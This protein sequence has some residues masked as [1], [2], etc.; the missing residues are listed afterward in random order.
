MRTVT[1]L[2]I[3]YSSMK[4]EDKAVK[5]SISLLLTFVLIFSVFS[6]A[7]CTDNTNSNSSEGNFNYN[8]DMQ[9]YYNNI[10]NA[11]LACTESDKGYY[12]RGDHGIVLFIDKKSMEGI[13]LCNK[14]NCMHNDPDVCDAYGYGSIQYN[15]GYLY[16]DISE[17]DSEKMSDV[18]YIFRVS[19]D[20]T[21]KEK[22]TNGFSETL[23]EWFIHRSY[24]Y[25]LTNKG[26]YR[27]PLSSPESEP[28]IIVS[29]KELGSENVNID[30]FIAYENYVYVSVSA[31]LE[32]ESSE[33]NNF[34]HLF[35]FDIESGKY[36]EIDFNGA[37]P[38]IATFIDGKMITYKS[39][40]NDDD[41]YN[42]IYY[43]S[44]LNGD[45]REKFAEYPSGNYLY[46]DGKYVYVDNGAYLNFSED[47]DYENPG[48]NIFGQTIK[49]YDL[50]MKD[51]ASFILPF[52]G[53]IDMCAQGT[54]H[55]LISNVAEDGS[56]ELY[57][58]DKNE[59]PQYKGTY[60]VKKEVCP[61]NWK[62][63][64]NTSENNNIKVDNSANK[65]N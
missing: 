5:K 63:L 65:N 42:T 13:P 17:Y 7:G 18:S 25:C 57:Y 62:N 4:K 51:I 28:K 33:D 48:K 31:L 10:S 32:E 8:T 59:I 54:G 3:I 19:E 21:E 35:A 34:T 9:Y 2:S 55:F 49:V 44:D 56:S 47:I 41:S 60:A 38:N 15:D 27:I 39:V 24:V 40:K 46:S 58:I 11:K 61:L 12:Y 22:I 20:G 14:T 53:W 26:M 6:I 30:K 16:T 29:F 50:K 43:I 45:N 36:S 23:L 37:T 52:D 1:F 64:S